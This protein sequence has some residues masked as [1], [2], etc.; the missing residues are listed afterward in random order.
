MKGIMPRIIIYPYNLGSQ[1]AKALAHNLPEFRSKRVRPD[2]RY[3]HNWNSHV[4]LNWGNTEL[5]RWYRDE[6]RHLWLNHATNVYLAVDKI[7]C[8]QTLKEKNIPTPEFTTSRAEADRLVREGKTIYC[9]TLTRASEGRGI[10]IATHWSELVNAPLYTV[11][12]IA[13]GE[14]RIHIFNNKVIDYQK[15]R[16]VSDLLE[17]E[18]VDENIRNH[19]NGW[20]FCR[21][22]LN[23]IEENETLALNT[24]KA[25]NLDFG[26]VDIIRDVNRKS[27]VL[28]VNTAPGLMG[29]TLQNYIGGIKQNYAYN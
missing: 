16:R 8:L 26:A 2:G 14:Y 29:T 7:T 9:R 13:R 1:S 19:N 5:P 15:K 3:K 11:R 22:N 17:E 6:K 4:I 21:D 27:Y 12:L 23:R 25:L 10:V 24:I 28:E 18:Q 20:V